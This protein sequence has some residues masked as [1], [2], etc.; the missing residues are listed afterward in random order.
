MLQS[1]LRKEKE[2]GGTKIFPALAGKQ[3]M[4]QEGIEADMGSYYLFSHV[5][6]LGQIHFIFISPLLQAPPSSL[7]E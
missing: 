6:T 2:M 1:H 7:E 4:G 3:Y 5:V